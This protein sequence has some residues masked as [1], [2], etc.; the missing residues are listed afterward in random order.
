M[1]PLQ[2]VT[3]SRLSSTDDFRLQVNVDKRLM[4]YGYNAMAGY[5]NREAMALIRNQLRDVLD[6]EIEHQLAVLIT[7]TP[8]FRDYLHVYLREYIEVALWSEAKDLWA[9]NGWHG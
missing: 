9:R 2:Q 5:L 6:H 7:S 3:K 4:A 8:A 1:A